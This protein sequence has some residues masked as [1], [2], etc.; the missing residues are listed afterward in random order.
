MIKQHSYSKSWISEE[1]PYIILHQQEWES[2]IAIAIEVEEIV[3]PVV[4]PKK[5]SFVKK[6]WHWLTEDLYANIHDSGYL[7]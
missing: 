3:Q 2:P 1:T 6:L 7:P 4:L 5:V